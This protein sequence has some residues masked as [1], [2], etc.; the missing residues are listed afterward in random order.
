MK[1]AGQILVT[2]FI[3]FMLASCGENPHNTFGGPT[4]AKDTASI[5]RDTSSVGTRTDR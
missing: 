1:R 3:I 5:N 2:G 4:E